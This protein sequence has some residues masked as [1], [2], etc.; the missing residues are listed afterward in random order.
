MLRSTAIHLQRRSEC[1]ERGFFASQAMH[2]LL[3]LSVVVVVNSLRPS[4]MLKAPVYILQ[5]KKIKNFIHIFILC[6]PER[7]LNSNIDQT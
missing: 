2:R 7:V 1:F 6:S 3:T 5:L 4:D